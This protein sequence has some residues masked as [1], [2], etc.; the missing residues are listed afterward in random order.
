[1]TLEELTDARPI[2]SGVP[3]LD[4][5]MRGGF[6]KGRAHLVEGRP[7]SGKTTIGLQFLLEGARNG[8]R[9]LYITLSESR[10]EL[11][12]VAD[13]HDWSLD[14][15]EIYELVPPELSLDKSTYQTL[16]HSS[17]LE[18]GETLEMAL[19]T[20]EK[21]QPSRLVFDSLSEIRLLS[22]GS[23]RYRRQVLALKSFVLL[24]DI[25]TLF[26]DD[27]T[28]EQDDLNLHSVCHGVLRLEQ[29]VPAY[30]GERRRIRVIKMRGIQIR[31][32]H[33][34][35]VILPGGVQ[36]FPRLVA[37]DHEQKEGGTEAFSNTS[38]DTLFKGGLPRGTSTLLMG[39]SGTGKSSISLRYA[40]SA[41]DRGE[42]VLI[43]S[44]DETKRVVL[45]RAAGLGMDLTEHL[46]SGLLQLDQIDAAELTPGQITGKIQRAVETD[47]ARMVIIDS[48]TGYLNSLAEEQQLLLQ[49]H[50]ILTYLNQ[51]G[52]VTLL[53]LANHGLIGQMSTSIDLTY[54]SDSVMLLRYFEADGRIR[55]AVSIVKKRT[56]P[57]EDSIR[58]FTL[59]VDGVTVGE[60]LSQFSGV[61]SGTPRFEGNRAS[62]M[63]GDV[64]GVV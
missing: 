1:M 32:G 47:G 64:S 36:V 6:A 50:E 7:G 4:H 30:G 38:L 24:K 46:A 23:L 17:D 42:R 43:L 29:N 55:R 9:C 41:L 31:G 49:M 39:P 19:A 57:H 15:I 58:E 8:E 3:G 34:D 10:R 52:V 16:V 35:L 37:A 53:L 59:S 14:G 44:F 2:A 62:L 33:H 12:S 21:Y 60:P 11:A 13:R 40:F 54:L 20:I 56:G 28:G 45:A 25:T 61:L 22:Q 51:R 5:L 27:L 63:N 18:L 26:L 48:L